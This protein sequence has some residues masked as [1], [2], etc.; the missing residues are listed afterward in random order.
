MDHLPLNCASQDYQ[1]RV[2]FRNP[3]SKS[4]T[5]LWF[6]EVWRE[7]IVDC[8]TTPVWQ[9]HLN[10]W[11]NFSP[12][13]APSVS[14]NAPL[15]GFQVQEWKAAAKS[16]FLIF[17][18]F[19]LLSLLMN[20]SHTSHEKWNCSNDTIFPANFP[21]LAFKP[22]SLLSIFV[23]LAATTRECGWGGGLCAPCASLS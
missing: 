21:F 8:P 7:N 23:S 9:N 20:K 13:C 6:L 5:T 12:T 16:F 18:S 14:H 22:I 2:C 4:A 19:S 3:I 1:T 11:G 17:F 15:N 10:C